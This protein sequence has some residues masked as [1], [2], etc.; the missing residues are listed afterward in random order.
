MGLYLGNSGYKS[1]LPKPLKDRKLAP[2]PGKQKDPISILLWCS[3][4]F[5]AGDV[6]MW[7]GQNGENKLQGPQRLQHEGNTEH[8]STHCLNPQLHGINQNRINK[9]ERPAQPQSPTGRLCERETPLRTPDGC[10]FCQSPSPRTTRPKT[11]HQTSLSPQRDIPAS[12][13][14]LACRPNLVPL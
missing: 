4:C 10:Q 14:L 8:S 12:H 2:G 9:K 1:S 5:E 13:K 6:H 7:L 3:R 11:V